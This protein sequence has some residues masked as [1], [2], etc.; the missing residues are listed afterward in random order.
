MTVRLF[1]LYAFT[2]TFIV[3]RVG[4]FNFSLRECIALYMVVFVT[5]GVENSTPSQHC[6]KY[7]SRRLQ[8]AVSLSIRSA[9]M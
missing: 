6:E 1:S 2:L 3:I 8:D 7:Y 9:P 5:C 4:T